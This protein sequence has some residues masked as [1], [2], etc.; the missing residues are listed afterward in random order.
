M[1]DFQEVK[2]DSLKKQTT[3][4]WINRPHS[5]T[6]LKFTS[7][8]IPSAKAGLGLSDHLLLLPAS[9][10]SPSSSSFPPSSFPPLR[11]SFCRYSWL[12]SLGL[13][14][15][16]LSAKILLKRPSLELGIFLPHLLKYWGYKC[17]PPHPI[18]PWS[19]LTFLPDSTNGGCWTSL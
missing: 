8:F 2:F 5:A 15:G 17:E 3:N 16:F 10:S 13:V 18:L 4:E 14:F 7:L 6:F 9:S 12:V 1:A 19:Y 11:W